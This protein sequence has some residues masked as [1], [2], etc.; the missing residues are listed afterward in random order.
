MKQCKKV[1]KRNNMEIYFSVVQLSD[2]ILL[3][4]VCQS[5]TFLFVYILLLK[6]SRNSAYID[7][8][9]IMKT[10]LKRKSE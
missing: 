2:N 9:D 5:I 8:V 6:I 3:A 1:K 7:C 10:Y 4:F